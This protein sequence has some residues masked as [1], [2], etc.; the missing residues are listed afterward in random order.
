MPRD[1]AETRE[2][3]IEAAHRL[4]YRKGYSR[5]GVDEIAAEAGVTKRT[6]YYH[7]KSK[8]DVLAEM[9]RAAHE[10]ASATT[11]VWAD[12]A[13]SDA[14]AFVSSIFKGIA[15]WSARSDFSAGGY[16][17]IV[18]EL[19]DLPG[20]PARAITRKHKATVEKLLATDLARRGVTNAPA[21]AREVVLLMEGSSVATLI[22]GG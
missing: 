19:G 15:K 11:Q 8:D 6:L 20:H 12:R 18:M 4:F 1:S 13:I 2:R 5:V 3:I 7:F 17:R 21:R 10:R 9:M 22:H 14:R 16:S